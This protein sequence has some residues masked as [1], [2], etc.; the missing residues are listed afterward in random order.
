MTEHS[1]FIRLHSRELM[2][3]RS[4]VQSRDTLGKARQTPT[5]EKTV[6]NGVLVRLEERVVRTLAIRSSR[7]TS[8]SSQK[9]FSPSAVQHA[10]C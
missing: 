5:S 4:L 9:R 10:S 7:N 8:V 3:N 2:P 1:S 6:D